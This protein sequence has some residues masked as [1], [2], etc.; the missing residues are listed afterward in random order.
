MFGRGHLPGVEAIYASKLRQ[1]LSSISR[2]DWE[3]DG[4]DFLIIPESLSTIEVPAARL[5]T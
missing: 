1:S 3:S 5:R 4:S 2:K